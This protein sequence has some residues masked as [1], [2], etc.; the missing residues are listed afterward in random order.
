MPATGNRTTGRPTLNE[1]AALADV[2]PITASRALRGVP[3]VAPMLAERVRQ[4][5]LELGYVANPAARALASRHSASV[6]VLIPSLSNH[7]FID[8]LE[9]IH[10][11]LHPRGLEVLIGNFHYDAGE[12]ENLIRNYL[13]YRPAGMLLTGLER[14]EAS[15]RMLAASHVPCV[16]MMD[17]A[18]DPAVP[19][20]GFSQQQAGRAA[21][22]HLL[23]QGRRR[24]GYV[25]AQLDSRV[26]H[27]AEGFRQALEE[28]GVYDASLE[29][30][31]P[32]R[33][34]IGLG[35]ELFA[36]LLA[37]CPDVD[38]LFFCNDD[39]A[40]GAIY[41]AQRQGIAVPGRVSMVGF[42]DLPPS[43]HTVPRLTS[44]R[45]PRAEIGQFAAQKLLD[46][47]DGKADPQPHMDL[48]FELIVRES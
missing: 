4:A 9:A 34:S 30:L 39:L 17:L 40:H 43:A 24:L 10:R 38:G 12:E 29:V 35:G 37:R 45:T 19:C 36:D 6:V 23:S 3:S 32:Q 47:L 48:G 15:Y 46:R 5:A 7:L 25:A 33:S 14:S 11:V 42:N 31:C 2:S 18:T 16:H 21:A 27:R 26:L 13:A 22:Q 8:T 1:V 44:I 28:Q 20:V 41:Q